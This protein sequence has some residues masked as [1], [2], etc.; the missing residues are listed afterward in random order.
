MR[1]QSVSI[2]FIIP[3]L[4]IYLLERLSNSLIIVFIVYAPTPDEMCSPTS[5]GS[6]VFSGLVG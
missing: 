4:F 3:K 6:T 1:I 2:F 5:I